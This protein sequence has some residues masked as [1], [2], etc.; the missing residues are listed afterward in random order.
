MQ[1]FC[2]VIHFAE[3]ELDE[4]L[5]VIPPDQLENRFGGD[6]P[7]LPEYWPPRNHTPP[8]KAIDDEEMGKLMLIPF[9]VYD[10]DYE[11]FKQ[12][13][14]LTGVQ[15]QKRIKPG[16]LKFKKGSHILIS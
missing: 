2:E 7:D 10:E 14:M 4:L 9:Y 3:D 16:Q 12:E 11:K 8:G 13:H 5:Y 1:P 6:K 15:I